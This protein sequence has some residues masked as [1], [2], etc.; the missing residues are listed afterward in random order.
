M[1]D[2]PWPGPTLSA[3]VSHGKRSSRIGHSQMQG[4]SSPAFFFIP[5]CGVQKR[6]ERSRPSFTPGS[7]MRSRARAK[8]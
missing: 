3:A 5:A 6:S 7:D 8:H 1:R 2:K 4:E